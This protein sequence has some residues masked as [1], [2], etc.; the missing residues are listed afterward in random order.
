MD[1]QLLSS[2]PIKSTTDISW[3]HTGKIN[4]DANRPNVDRLVD[5][6]KAYGYVPA[7]PIVVM[8]DGLILSGR[9]RYT[10][11]L[12][13]QQA[14]PSFEVYYLEVGVSIEEAR[15]MIRGIE[16]A[17]KS[18][19]PSDFLKYDAEAL[20]DEMAIAILDHVSRW[21]LTPGL[22]RRS[23][24]KLGKDRTLVF[25]QY[26]AEIAAELTVRGDPALKWVQRTTFKSQ[27]LNLYVKHFAAMDK[28]DGDTVD[29]DH[30]K[31]QIYAFGSDI[32]PEMNGSGRRRQEVLRTLYRYKSRK[33][34]PY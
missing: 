18:W 3:M 31:E 22:A 23:L 25:C 26:L 12:E 8:S 14:D 1:T 27:I 19:T 13:V 10:A 29:F 7:F 30:L 11:A 5:S 33:K 32:L 6:F 16:A 21:G 2:S 17:T 15:E 24:T 4:R 9:H 20:S 28:K 34:L